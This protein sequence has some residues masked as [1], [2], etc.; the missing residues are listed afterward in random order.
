[1]KVSKEQIVNGIVS[2][3]ESEVIPLIDDKATQVIA[4]IAIKS[5]KANK[6]LSDSIFGSQIIKNALREDEDGMF[7]IGEMFGLIQESVK[8]LGPFP[9]T[10][11]PIPIISPHES[12]FNFDESDIAEIKKCIERS[13]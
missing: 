5:V 1:M 10:I 8:E 2:Y 3:V 12:T 4:S 6:K 9:I 11:P 13:K 7:E